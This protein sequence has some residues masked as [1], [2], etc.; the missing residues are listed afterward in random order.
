MFFR[1]IDIV[2][3]VILRQ[4]HAADSDGSFFLNGNLCQIKAE[5][6]SVPAF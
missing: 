5:E 6:E 4:S 3:S 1:E 2:N